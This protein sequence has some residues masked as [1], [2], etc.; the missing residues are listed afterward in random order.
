MRRRMPR[1]EALQLFWEIWGGETR[2]LR[3][4]AREHGVGHSLVRAWCDELGIPYPSSGEGSRIGMLRRKAEGSNRSKR[5]VTEGAR[6]DLEDYLSMLWSEH[7]CDEFLERRG[8][9][10]M[11][12]EARSLAY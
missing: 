6:Q 1:P 10:A 11:G 7:G 8:A 3:S 2:S 5:S 4:I 9:R 12:R